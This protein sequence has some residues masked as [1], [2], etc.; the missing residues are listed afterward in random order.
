MR[1][2]APAHH[3]D[4]ALGGFAVEAN[5]GLEGGGGD[6]EVGRKDEESGSLPRWKASAMCCLSER[7]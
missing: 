6:V 4:F 1:D 5:D 7:R 2:E 3:D